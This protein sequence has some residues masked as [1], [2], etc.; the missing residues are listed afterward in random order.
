MFG[1]ECHSS[2]QWPGS[3]IGC[4]KYSMTMKARNP[5]SSNDP[6]AALGAAL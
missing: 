1:I 2:G 6:A 5:K 4:E 3:Y